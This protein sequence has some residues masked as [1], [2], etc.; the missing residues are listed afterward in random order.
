LAEPAPE[1]PADRGSLL[2]SLGR[3]AVVS[4]LGLAGALSG[5]GGG[6]A[7]GSP[8]PSVGAIPTAAGS[9]PTASA[10][11]GQPLTVDPSLLA[12]LPGQVAGIAIQPS[13]EAAAL[14]DDADLAR[15]AEGVAVGIVAGGD[16]PGSDLAV[17]TVVRLRPGVYSQAFYDAWRA[18][19]DRAAC[20]PAAGVA[21]HDR[22]DLAGHG[23]DIAVC[24]GGAR[25]YHTHLDGDIL[26]S[27]TA[28]GDQHFGDLV[29]AGLRG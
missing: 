10:D 3:I 25:T 26:V 7:N 22:Q 19:Y 6:A 1:R 18:D 2:A 11:R 15:S 12:V 20:E 5:C 13:P 28:I 21:D 4:V 23:V 8:A 27:V 16:P 24:S 14:V 29:M 17:S 9:S